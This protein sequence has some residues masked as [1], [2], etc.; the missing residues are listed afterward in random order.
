[1]QTIIPYISFNGSCREAMNF[2]R[3]C[4]GGELELIEAGE[5]LAQ[6]APKDSGK[7]IF[8]SSL[9]KDGVQIM[10]G[11]DM[12]GPY[13]DASD[14]RIAMAYNCL[15]KDEIYSLFDKLLAGGT[16]LSTVKEESWGLFGMLVDRFGI[17]W[18]LNLNHENN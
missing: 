2:Y 4:L 3:E 10:M 16:A 15:D 11:S 1:M 12:M 8:H 5:Q 6:P 9:A 18:M 17:K 14:G 13:P 7:L